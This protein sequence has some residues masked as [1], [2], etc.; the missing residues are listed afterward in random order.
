MDPETRYYMESHKTEAEME[1]IIAKL[2]NTISR[3]EA[4]AA[5]AST[6]PGTGGGWFDTDREAFE[7]ELRERR[8]QR[9]HAVAWLKHLRERAA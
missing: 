1:E 9:N 6:E 8:C 4:S 3:I 5:Q 2:D 7:S